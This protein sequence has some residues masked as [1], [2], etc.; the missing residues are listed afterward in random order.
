MLRAYS[1]CRIGVMMLKVGEQE[2]GDFLSRHL[3]IDSNIVILNSNASKQS[4]YPL[5]A[6]AVCQHKMN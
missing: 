1:W 2:I 5:S 3:I 6:T 4:L